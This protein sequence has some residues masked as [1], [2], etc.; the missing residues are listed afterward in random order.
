MP[1]EVKS[2]KTYKRHVALNNL[3]SVED[4]DVQSAYVLSEANLSVEERMGKPVRYV[5]L[6]L[7]PFVARGLVS[8]E[9]AASEELERMGLSAQSLVVPPMDLSAFA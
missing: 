5:P 2:G 3:L 1:V 9:I 8:E 4:F 7:V 6:Y